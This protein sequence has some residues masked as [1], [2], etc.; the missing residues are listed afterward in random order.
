MNE[1]VVNYKGQVLYG[2]VIW[3]E[4]VLRK[5]KQEREAIGDGLANSVIGEKTS[6]FHQGHRLPWNCSLNNYYVL[7]CVKDAVG[8]KDKDSALACRSSLNL[9][10][11]IRQC[12]IL[13]CVHT[14]HRHSSTGMRGEAEGPNRSKA[15]LGNQQSGVLVPALAS[16]RKSVDLSGSSLLINTG[17]ELL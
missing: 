4:E 3:V 12:F 9:R 17:L 13:G 11:V 5:E 8:F 6:S 7:G 10:G 1:C 14:V 15:S 2:D 16:T